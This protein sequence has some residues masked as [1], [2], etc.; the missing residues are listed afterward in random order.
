MKQNVGNLEKLVIMLV[1]NPNLW[2]MSNI[3]KRVKRLYLPK[4]TILIIVL[5]TAKS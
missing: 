5:I 2:S 1:L 3:I 4:I